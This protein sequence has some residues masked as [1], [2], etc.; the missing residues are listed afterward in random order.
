MMGNWI[1]TVTYNVVATQVLSQTVVNSRRAR[2]SRRVLRSLS[3]GK[4]DQP[5]DLGYRE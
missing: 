4:L 3:V 1:A 2:L 5:L